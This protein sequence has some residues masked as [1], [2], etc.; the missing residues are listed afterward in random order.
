MSP[1]KEY[2]DLNFVESLSSH[3]QSK[4]VIV[5]KSKIVEEEK[6]EEDEDLWKQT[7]DEIMRM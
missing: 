2:D 6:M 7:N 3:S 4:E 5:T 1:F